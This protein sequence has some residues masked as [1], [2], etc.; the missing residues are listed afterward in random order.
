MCILF[1]EN[2][3]DLVLN[4]EIST[5]IVEADYRFAQPPAKPVVT[6]VPGDKRVTLY[7]DTRAEESIDI[8]SI[9]AKILNL[10]TSL[11]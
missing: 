5:R 2:L 1:G 10:L 7:W 11:R 6:A 8:K 4:A 9:E 3:N